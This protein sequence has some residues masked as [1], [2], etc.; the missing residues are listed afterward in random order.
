M[1][2]LLGVVVGFAVAL[3]VVPR[4]SAICAVTEAGD[5]LITPA[6][7][8]LPRDGG[9][10]VGWENAPENKPA[11][12]SISWTVTTGTKPVDLVRETLA[13][14]LIVLRPP[15]DTDVLRISTGTTE[16]ARYTRDPNAAAF[17]PG[18]PK[19]SKLVMTSQPARYD[20]WYRTVTTTLA[21]PVP[22][23]AVAMI[24]YATRKKKRVAISFALVV[25]GNDTAIAFADPGRCS[26][27]PPGMVPPK[28]GEKVTLVWVDAFGRLSKPSAPI[29]MTEIKPVKPARK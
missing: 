19:A 3:A 25:P 13:P 4:A 24:T 14:G 12:Q 2:R 9:I 28:A 20:G 18:A 1:N 23:D 11:N 21:A 22:G 27:N 7:A 8:F 5:T 29:A 16:L 10:L 6:A 26:F 15:A 17:T